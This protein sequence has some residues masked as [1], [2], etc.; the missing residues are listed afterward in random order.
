MPITKKEA[1][2]IIKEWNLF[3]NKFR[4]KGDLYQDL[5]EKFGRHKDTIATLIRYPEQY[6]IR[7]ERVKEFC[8]PGFIK[9]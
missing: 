4:K 7:K 1:W 8:P 3:C 5:A 2:E 6:R 9:L